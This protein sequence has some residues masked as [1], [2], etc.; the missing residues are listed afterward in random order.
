MSVGLEAFDVSGGF[1]ENGKREYLISISCPFAARRWGLEKRSTMSMI[2][3][4]QVLR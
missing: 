3:R 4:L 1:L 2:I